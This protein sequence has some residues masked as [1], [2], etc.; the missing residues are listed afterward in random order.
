[1]TDSIINRRRI[2]VCFRNECQFIFRLSQAITFKTSLQLNCVILFIC[3]ECLEVKVGYMNTEIDTFINCHPLTWTNLT[4]HCRD[5]VSSCN[6]CAV[7]Q[8][9]Q[10]DFKVFFLQLRNSWTCREVRVLPHTKVCDYS[11]YKTLLMMDWWGP[12]HVEL[13][14]SAE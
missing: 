3:I 9:T 5:R 14:K 4:W 6:I 1:M 10:S 11:L 2:V 13:T 7:Q 8:D 12:K